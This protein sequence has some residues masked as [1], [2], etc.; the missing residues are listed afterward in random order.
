VVV[1]EVELVVDVLVDDDVVVRGAVVPV[2]RG[3]ELADG[4]SSRPWNTNADTETTAMAAT[5]AAP[6]TG[7]RP[8]NR[9][10]YRHR[11]RRR[12]A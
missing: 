5:N 6:I 10:T 1:V 7:P 9:P 4:A 8:P 11:Q 3:C 2:V 12:G